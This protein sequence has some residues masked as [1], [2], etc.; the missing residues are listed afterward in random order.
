MYLIDIIFIIYFFIQYISITFFSPLSLPRSSYLHTHQT[1]CSFSCSKTLKN[2]K[3]IETIPGMAK[4]NHNHRH[5]NNDKERK[6]YEV[7]FVFVSDSWPWGLLSSVVDIPSVAPLKKL[8]FLQQQVSTANGFLFR[9]RMLCLFFL[10][11]S[12]ICLAWACAGLVHVFHRAC[13]FLCTL[14]LFCLEDAF[15]L[16]SSTI[17]SS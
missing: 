5:H 6:T 8:T 10:S 1:F 7:H 17:H 4:P 16:D 13:Q 2:N 12:G 9:G 3:T 14:V 15:S 11:N